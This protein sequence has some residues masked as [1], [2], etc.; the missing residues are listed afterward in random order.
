MW[1]DIF[2]I[3]VL[4][5]FQ[6]YRGRFEYYILRICV[7]YISYAESFNFCSRKS[8]QLDSGH[9][10]WLAFCDLWILCQLHFQ[11][12]CDAIQICLVCAPLSYESG[13]GE[14]V[15]N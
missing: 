11:S 7:L 10:T 9:K 13:N 6:F 5:N 12:L 2:L 4:G 1:V 15:F 14:V 8:I 3:Y